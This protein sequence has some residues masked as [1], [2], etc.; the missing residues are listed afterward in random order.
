MS[1]S[2]GRS[3]PTNALVHLIFAYPNCLVPLLMQRQNRGRRAV[4]QPETPSYPWP[5]RV[6]TRSGGSMGLGDGGNLP[7]IERG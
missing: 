3:P 4:L 6:A 2:L 7:T 5:P 1:R